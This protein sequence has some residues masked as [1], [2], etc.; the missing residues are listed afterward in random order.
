MPA[1]EGLGSQF[2]S[3][4]PPQ[5]THHPAFISF[6]NAVGNEITTQW[7]NWIKSMKWGGLKVHGFG[8]MPLPSGFGTSEWTGTGD[9]GKL[10]ADPYR[11]SVDTILNSVIFA[12]HRTPATVKLLN[13]L[14]TVLGQKFDAWVSSY[15]FANVPYK[16]TTT[17]TDSYSGVFD[18]TNITAN[19]FTLGHGDNPS[20]IQSAWEAMLTSLPQPVFRIDHPLCR[21][22][23]LTNAVSSVVEQ[24]FI[25]FF[26][27]NTVGLNNTVSGASK[28]YS[29]EG[30]DTSKNDGTIT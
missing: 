19:L 3:H 30:T 16:G 27:V 8:K 6:I 2:I 22:R 26:L 24:Q 21:V 20:G 5:V 7:S 29:G 18:A 12:P 1:P 17:A 25:Q 28:A 13:D 4:M 15:T 9:N 23:N 11:I 14:N 10:T